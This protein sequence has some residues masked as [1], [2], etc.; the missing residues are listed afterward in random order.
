MEQYNPLDDIFSTTTSKTP[1]LVRVNKIAFF[2]SKRGFGFY[3]FLAILK[4]ASWEGASAVLVLITSI[5][6]MFYLFL[7]TFF[8]G[9]RGVLQHLAGYAKGVS[10]AMCVSG[11]IFQIESWQSSD[12][13]DRVCERIDYVCRGG[14]FDGGYWFP[15]AIW[16]FSM[17][18]ACAFGIGHAD[19]HWRI[20]GR[21]G[22]APD[23]TMPPMEVQTS[24]ETVIGLEIHVQLSTQSKV[25]CSDATAFGA[26][27]NSQVSVVSLAHPGTLPRL[28][29]AVVE[30]AV[31]LGLALGGKI[32]LFSTFDRKNYFY[33]DLPKGYQITQD[34]RPISVGG[35]L[36]LG[37]GRGSMG[38]HHIHIEEDAGKSIHDQVP[39]DTL[40]DLNRSGAPL[41]EIVSLPDLRGAEDILR[42]WKPCVNWCDG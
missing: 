19:H 27:P 26:T 18:C 31:Q 25:F 9:S 15:P 32:N 37:E 40:I 4:G 23:Q 5:L 2:L 29:R 30:M 1:W 6:S 12:V 36:P 34:Q 24:W 8:M 16:A 3:C 22:H 38:I 13:Y 7:P 21:Y 33:A 41:L 39:S 11:L 10:V 17:A 35:R 20:F 42:L 28:N 14:G